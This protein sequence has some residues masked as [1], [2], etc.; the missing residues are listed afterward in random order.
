MRPKE[1]F[2]NVT[3]MK[4]GRPELATKQMQGL[5]YMETARAR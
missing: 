4:L 1:I 5:K 2:R 3:A